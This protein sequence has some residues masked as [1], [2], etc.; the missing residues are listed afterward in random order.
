MFSFALVSVRVLSWSSIVSSGVSAAL[1]L[2]MYALFC[3][4]LSAASWWDSNC[5]FWPYMLYP[6]PYGVYIHHQSLRL[7]SLTC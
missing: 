1:L 5:L 7:V 4:F 3:I 2:A 6:V